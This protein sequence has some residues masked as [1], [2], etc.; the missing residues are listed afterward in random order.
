M[1]RGRLRRGRLR[2]GRLRRGRLR[3]RRL[4]R[5]RLR[6]RRLRRDRL[7]GAR[8]HRQRPG[9]RTERHVHAAHLQGPPP[10]VQFEVDAL[11]RVAPV[12]AAAG[13]RRVVA[14]GAHRAAGFEQHEIEIIDQ[15][16]ARRVVPAQHRAQA[17]GPLP[18][19]L[20][21][22][23][24][25]Q[26]GRI[27]H[28]HRT[29]RTRQ[30]GGQPQA[31]EAG[32]VAVL[33]AAAVAPAH[34]LGAVDQQRL[35]RRA[36]GRTA[37]RLTPA[38]TQH[39][40]R[41]RD[42]AGRH[43]G[44]AEVLVPGQRVRQAPAARR[45]R[46]A[47]RRG[48]VGAGRAQLG[49]DAAVERRPAARQQR[50]AL[51]VARH[52]RRALGGIGKAHARRIERRPAAAQADAHVRPFG[53]ADAE[54]I[55]GGCRG[56]QGACIDAAVAVAVAPGI[57]SGE[58]QQG[59]GVLVQEMIALPAIVGVGAGGLHPPGIGVDGGTGGA[60]LLE[61]LAQVE[62]AAGK[63]EAGRQL[64]APGRQRLD[65]LLDRLH[66]H[67]RTGR[68]AAQPPRAHAAVARCQA[69]HVGAVPGAAVGAA[70]VRFRRPHEAR[71]AGG[72]R[73]TMDGVHP[74]G[75]VGMRR[76][77]VAGAQAGV[78]EGDELAGARRIVAGRIGRSGCGHHT[79]REPE[80][81][82]GDTRQRTGIGDLHPD[83]IAQMCD[84]VGAA[85]HAQLV[86]AG[87]DH[88]QAGVGKRLLEPRAVGLGEGHRVEGPGQGVD[89]AAAGARTVLRLVG[90][91]RAQ[92]RQGRTQGVDV[93]P[94]I[95]TDAEGR[96]VEARHPAQRGQRLAPGGRDRPGEAQDAARP[97]AGREHPR[98]Q[99]ARHAIDRHR[100]EVAPA[101]PRLRRR[102]IDRH[103]RKVAVAREHA[104]ARGVRR[105]QGEAQHFG[106]RLGHRG[107]HEI[108][109]LEE[110]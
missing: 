76:G 83:R 88:L 6:R 49:L 64:A 18:G 48:K 45:G 35:Q 65:V 81:G 19:D 46:G 22:A 26:A 34:R 107:S 97:L 84:R 41:A 71:P 47:A 21:Q 40:R 103:Q 70:I 3:R 78:G 79:D 5:R 75:E 77:R 4:R 60:R 29:V 27:F 30:A 15:G 1:R 58:D 32:A 16:L 90:A 93:G 100:I 28:Q 14:P 42:H 106:G 91:D 36:A 56:V 33:L 89:P 62:R 37:E 98:R 92:G 8:T 55:L 52:R 61:Q 99:H 13:A 66:Q 69:G 110:S 80:R 87:L 38:L 68:D 72:Y 2:R 24:G 7:A 94:D 12:G 50:Q 63:V 95:G 86:A 82:R 104:P 11:D 20:A 96:A 54:H 51:A 108:A 31:A 85:D 67:A 10:R 74:A 9:L 101:R 25:R 109:F 43:R 102:P 105:Q 44:A 57:A 39:G 23:A 59:L 17:A 53:G 73:P